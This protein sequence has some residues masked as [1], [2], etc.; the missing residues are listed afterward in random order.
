[1]K[2]NNLENLHKTQVEMLKTFIK[3]C[4]KLNLQYFLIGGSALGAVRH[5][6]FIPWDDDIDIGMPREDYERFLKE[7]QSHLPKKLF[8]QSIYSEP[9]APF[10]FAKIRN[11]D[12]TFIESSIKHLD[13]NHGVYLDIFPLDGMGNNKE[14]LE[15]KHYKYRFLNE[16][17]VH[18]TKKAK[19]T[20]TIRKL[21]YTILAIPYNMQTIEQRIQKY[22]T[23]YS[24]KKSKFVGNY[25]GMWGAKEI[26]EKKWFSNGKETTFEN[27]KVTIP[28]DYDSYLKKMYGNYMQLPPEEKRKAPHLEELDLNIGYKEYLKM[29]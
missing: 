19:Y 4:K 3:V 18:I 2:E 20:S 14:D 27:I 10:H 29:K 1:M 28:E 26:Y 7:G 13:I 23:K 15:N 24:Y 12:T 25:F 17:Y 11:S 21:Y 6:G 9:S 8:V 5:K 16:I 22:A